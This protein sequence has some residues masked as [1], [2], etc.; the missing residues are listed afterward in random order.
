[1]GP[2]VE[3]DWLEKNLGEAKLRIFDTTAFLVPQSGGPYLAESGLEEFQKQHIPNAGFL[4]LTEELSD[5]SHPL[6]FM[7]PGERQFSEVV[8]AKGV[9][10]DS[11]VVLY[12]AGSMM[13]ST[14]VWWMFRAFGFDRVAVLDGGWNK[15]HGEGRP[16]SSKEITPESGAFTAQVRVELIAGKDEVREAIGDDRFCTV[17][18]L[19]SEVYRGEGNRHSGRPGHIPG[20]KNVDHQDLVDPDTGTFLE[21]GRLKE[22]FAGVGAFEK[23]RII[24]YCGGGIAS[25]LGAMALF[26]AG[27]EGTAVYD[28]SMREWSGDP[29][30]PLVVGGE[31]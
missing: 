4:D 14:R 24:L 31:P 19:S 5:P 11:F 2:L 9:S 20:S 27:H 1:L 8:A 15:W 3:T 26:L 17:Y 12:S 21:P 25:T 28:G 22:R 16:V 13:W 23:E 29:A 6:P 30:L 18:A 7:M 10:N